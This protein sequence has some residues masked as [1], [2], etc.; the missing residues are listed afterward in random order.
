MQKKAFIAPFRK[1]EE[2]YN[3][4]KAYA[5]EY[6]NKFIGGI[7]GGTPGTLVAARGWQNYA[8]DGGKK[9]KG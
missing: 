1:E 3:S 6:G 2:D 9:F 4:G 8:S 7:I 5:K